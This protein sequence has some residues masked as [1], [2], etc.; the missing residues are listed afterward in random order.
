LGPLGPRAPRVR[1][2]EVDQERHNQET[3][4]RRHFFFL[5]CSFFCFKLEQ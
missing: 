4:S 2:F 3:G 1:D 5:R